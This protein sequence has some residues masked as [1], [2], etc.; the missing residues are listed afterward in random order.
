MKTAKSILVA[1]V[2]N[3][4][5]SVFE[6]IGG[7][8]TDS[9]AITSDAVHD[10]GDA[11]SIGISFYLERIS[12]RKPD[13][14]YT[15]GYARY[16]VIGSVITTFILLFGSTAMILNAACRLIKPAQIN[17]NG[18]LIFAV[19]GVC[20]NFV[21]AYFTRDGESLNSKA[22]NLHMLE[23]V[24][25]W[26]VV[27]VGAVIMKFTGFSLID[28]IMSIC[29]SVFI[30]INAVKN[31]KTVIDLFLEKIP[32]GTDISEIKEHICAIDGVVDVH[33][34]HIRS[35]DGV[36][37]CATMHVVVTDAD[38]A[39]IKLKVR[40]ELL[41]HGICHATLELETEGERC[42][43]ENCTVEFETRLHHH[44]H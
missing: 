13:E 39:E 44:H 4:S 20:V 40:E 37:N 34:I 16:S 17:Y 11:I 32:D 43:E 26:A 27:L 31:L 12:K 2:L 22:V 9:V 5:F 33:H 36:N 25:G 24:L 19:V 21:A 1:F 42:E 18:M 23:D 8:L 10:F 28:P 29:V 3:L 14:K 6:L 15:Y 35:F 41:E 7:I 30:L 38:F